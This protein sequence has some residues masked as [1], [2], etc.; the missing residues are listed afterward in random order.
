M[1]TSTVA[2]A[3]IARVTGSGLRLAELPQTFDVDEESDLDHLRRAC[4]PDGAAA[5]VTWAA[6]KR[7]RLAE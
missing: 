7:L 2:D 3:L 5:P 4:A 6:L 1:S